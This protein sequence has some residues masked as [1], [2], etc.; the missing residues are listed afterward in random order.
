MVPL[1]PKIDQVSWSQTQNLYIISTYA[2]DKEKGEIIL[3][4]Q[5]AS[6]TEIF[7]DEFNWA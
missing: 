2:Q 7:T 5:E 3:D 6:F 1:S 4:L